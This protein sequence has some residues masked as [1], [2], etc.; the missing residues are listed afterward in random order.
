MP[1]SN[2]RGV[3]KKIKTNNE[4]SNNKK[5][6]K[7]DENKKNDRNQNWKKKSKIHMTEIKNEKEMKT[8]MKKCKQENS[9]IK[10]CFHSIQIYFLMNFYF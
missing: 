1:I 5:Y 3:F 10:Y 2:P 9:L 4:H 6:Y 8:K 7:I